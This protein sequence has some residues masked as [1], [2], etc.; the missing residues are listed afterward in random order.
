MQDVVRPGDSSC[1]EM[2][3]VNQLRQSLESGEKY[4]LQEGVVETRILEA[5]LKIVTEIWEERILIWA[6]RTNGLHLVPRAGRP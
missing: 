3:R 4:R 1:R 5:R 6:A 2:Q